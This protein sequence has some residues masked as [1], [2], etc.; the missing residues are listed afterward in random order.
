MPDKAHVEEDDGIPMPS[1]NNNGE[2]ARDFDQGGFDQAS[3][4]K[5]LRKIDWTLI[6]F[7][8]LLY[9]LSFLDRTNIGNARLAGL[10]TDLGLEG[11]DYNVALAVFFPFYIISE[12]PSNLA[13]KKFSPSVWI[14][15]IMII[16][17][18]VCTLMGLVTNYAGLLA[19][20]MA[21]G[22]AE[23]GLFPGINY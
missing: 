13:I 15:C 11:L 7:L 23:G 4:K 2:Y 12:V 14:P 22:L 17:G 18:I 3:T 6:P 19:C 20:R 8:A 21:L 5:L 1:N 16:W 9:L 10:E